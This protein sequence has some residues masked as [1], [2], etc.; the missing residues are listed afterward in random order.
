MRDPAVISEQLSNPAYAWDQT[1][2]T[3]I[4]YAANGLD[5]YVN[6]KGQA[7]SY[8]ANGNLTSDGRSI[9]TYDVENRLVAV[10]GGNI[11][12]LRYDPFGRLFEVRDRNGN[13]RRNVYDGDALVAEYDANNIMLRRFVHG[14]GAGDDPLVA[15]GG[16]S[17]ALTNARFLYADRLGSIVLHADAA[18]TSTMVNAY[19]E[20][21]VADAPINTRFGYTGQAWV[22]EAGLYYYKARM[23][24]PTL[25]R[26]MQTDPIGYADGMNLYAYVGN[27]PVNGV[28]PT[29]LV[30][31]YT[32]GLGNVYRYN[33]VSIE[34][35]RSCGWKSIGN[36][37]SWRN[38][39]GGAGFNRGGGSGS[40]GRPAKPKTPPKEEP[41][42]EEPS[43]LENIW[44]CTKDQYGFGSGDDA[45]DVALGSARATSEALAAPI[46]KELAGVRRHPGTSPVTNPISYT[47][48][49]TRIGATA[50][51]TGRAARVSN[52]LTGTARVASALGRANAVTGTLLLLYDAGS[53]GV[54]AYQKS[55]N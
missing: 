49:R 10:S 9:Y 4:D 48:H 23:Y 52:L 32:D 11:A 47:S 53:I 8:D 16:A 19:D 3:A 7:Y 2:S 33:C 39:T 45:G 42:S 41:Q 50:K 31:D 1:T 18:G 12:E 27:D 37:G 29:G 17:T 35:A 13:I 51:F 38:Y 14:T 15:Y 34:G 40:G 28:D 44:D 36:D 25:G 6:V 20:Y 26:F 46:P 22:P 24:S 21:G 30:R 5:Q 43:T 55:G 54:C